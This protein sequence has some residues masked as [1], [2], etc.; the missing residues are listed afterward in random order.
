MVVVVAVTVAAGAV[1]GLVAVVEAEDVT[2]D[3][4]EDAVVVVVV[5]VGAVEEAAGAWVAG[6]KW[7]SRPIATPASSLPGGRRTRW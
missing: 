3:V 6:P 1:V 4:T 7:S 5:A 2:E